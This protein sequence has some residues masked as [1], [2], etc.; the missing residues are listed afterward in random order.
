LFVSLS[1]DVQSN[2]KY[3]AK[4]RE[5]KVLDNEDES[6]LF[7]FAYKKATDNDLAIDDIEYK[8][9][10]EEN[11]KNS[12]LIRKILKMLFFHNMYQFYLITSFKDLS[13]G[14]LTLESLRKN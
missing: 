9:E 4:L 14:L 7:S 8:K 10:K 5:I 2:Q 3:K 1:F 12:K 13:N 6:L 11:E